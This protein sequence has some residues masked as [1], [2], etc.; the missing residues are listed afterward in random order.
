MIHFLSGRMRRKKTMPREN[1]VTH[2]GIGMFVKFEHFENL[3]SA[4][5][6]KVPRCSSPSQARDMALIIRVKWIYVGM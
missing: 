2:Y 6:E 5:D 4:F 1:E 3:S